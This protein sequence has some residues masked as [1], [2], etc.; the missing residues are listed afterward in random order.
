MAGIEP[1]G[2]CV[3][4]SWLAPV[5]CGNAEDVLGAADGFAIACRVD[6]YPLALAI[7]ARSLVHATAG[8]PTT[9]QREDAAPAT[10]RRRERRAMSRATPRGSTSRARAPAWCGIMPS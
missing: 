4:T 6:P 10:A 1:V 3:W 5:T 2:L 8:R 7:A 9:H